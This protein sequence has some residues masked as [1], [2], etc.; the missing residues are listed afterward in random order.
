V[1]GGAN[2][3]VSSGGTAVGA[4]LSGGVET[5]SSGGVISGTLTFAG[6]GTLILNQASN[7][8]AGALV[9][10]FSNVNEIIDLKN[11]AFA[12]APTIGFVEAGNNQSGTL[13]VSAGG[14]SDT[15]TLIGSYTAGSFTSG[16]DG[17]GGTTIVDPP[18][19]TSGVVAPTQHA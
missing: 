13:T 8:G 7:F 12:S 5:V 14:V 3:F 19:A 1:S 17:T 10:G 2:L 15:L 11:I 6:S 16:A 4:T 9:A 18:A